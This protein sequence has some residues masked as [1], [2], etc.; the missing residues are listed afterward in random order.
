[1]NI[2][3][4]LTLLFLILIPLGIIWALNI[5]FDVHI[6]YTIETWAAIVILLFAISFKTQLN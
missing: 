1:M 3:G 6:L 2:S 5:L 4:L